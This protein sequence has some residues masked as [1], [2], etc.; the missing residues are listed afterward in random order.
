MTE[1]IV[2]EALTY[3]AEHYASLPGGE[4]QARQLERDVMLQIIDQR[5]RD[6]LAEMDYLREGINLRAMAQMDPLV[7]WQREGFAMFGQLMD[8]IDDDYLRYVLHVQAVE[9]PAAAPDLA[10]AVYEAADDPVAGTAAL[11]GQLLAEQGIGVA[12]TERAGG[13]A[14]RLLAQDGRGAS[15]PTRPRR[16]TASGRRNRWPGRGSTRRPSPTTAGCRSGLAGTGGQGAAGEG[17]PQR[18]VL[19]RERQEV[20]VLPWR[21]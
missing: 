2:T 20:Q 1:S 8:S 3:Y 17:R 5:W 13:G 9:E 18:P 15:S 10:Q 16:P 4:E 6:H 7:A 14:L 21:A 19:V 12:G 11:A